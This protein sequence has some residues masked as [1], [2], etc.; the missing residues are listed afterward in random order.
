MRLY[1]ESK[2]YFHINWMK[3]VMK[4]YYKLKTYL[5][6]ERKA[7]FNDYFSLFNEILDKM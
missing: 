5:L 3:K 2:L 1:F 4:F 7:L 6:T